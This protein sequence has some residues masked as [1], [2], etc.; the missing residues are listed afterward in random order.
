MYAIVRV[1]LERVC[2]RER[3]AIVGVYVAFQ[4]TEALILV[5]QFDFDFSEFA[6]RYFAGVAAD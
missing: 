1:A 5:Q 4:P 6:L 3:L 2:N